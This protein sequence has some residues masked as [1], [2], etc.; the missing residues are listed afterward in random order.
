MQDS[1]PGSGHVIAEPGCFGTALRSLRYSS[2]TPNRVQGI[3]FKVQLKSIVNPDGTV[4]CEEAGLIR[5]VPGASFEAG[6]LRT[7]L[8]VIANRFG[9]KLGPDLPILNLRLQDGSRLAAMIPPLVHRHPLLTVC[10][11]TAR[12]FSLVDLIE[13]GMLTEAQA[14]TLTEAVR[15]GKNLL[16]TGA[17]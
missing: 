3:T 7:L 14:A 17:T 6:A 10:K 13:A 4:W 12:N 2:A 9:K 15:S 16:I 5:L 1:R 8:E 11:F